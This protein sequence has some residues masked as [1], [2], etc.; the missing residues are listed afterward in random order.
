MNKQLLQICFKAELR[1]NA[2]DIAACIRQ[3][4]TALEKRS[5]T[6]EKHFTPKVVKNK[7]PH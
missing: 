2:N 1:M 6:R 7:D 4:L 5:Y 3:F